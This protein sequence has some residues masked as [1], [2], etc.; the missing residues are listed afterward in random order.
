MRQRRAAPSDL[1][2]DPSDPSLSEQRID[3]AFQLADH[4]ADP[5]SLDQ[6]LPRARFPDTTDLAHQVIVLPRALYHDPAHPKRPKHDR[7]DARWHV[8]KRLI[9]R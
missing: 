7:T 3:G 8:H 2:T 4:R 6:P 9:P 1:P 5:S